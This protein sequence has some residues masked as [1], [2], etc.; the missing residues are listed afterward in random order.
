[1]DERTF[2]IDGW[3]SNIE[4]EWLYEKAV[5]LPFGELVVELGSWKGR[6]TS[7]LY[8]ACK[9]KNTVIAIDTWLGQNG[10]RFADHHEV[11]KGD[12]FLEFLDNMKAMDFDPKWYNKWENINP[13]SPCYLRMDSKDAF[14][15]FDDESITFFFDDG[16]HAIVGET[17]DNFLPKLKSGGIYCGHDWYY[18]KIQED[19]TSRGH[20]PQ[21]I[22]NI[23]WFIK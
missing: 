8:T 23:W 20:S 3:M 19:V 1:M 10:L 2:A 7:A 15:I 17:M 16:D 13:I 18:H 22:D 4:I 11:L 14:Q 9:D 5:E 12:I 6:S 21:V